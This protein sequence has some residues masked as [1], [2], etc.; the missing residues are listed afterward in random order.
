MTNKPPMPKLIIDQLAQQKGWGPNDLQIEVA[1]LFP[2]L[3]VGY[4][5]ILAL[6][7]N[8]Q[9]NPNLR[10]L[11]AVAATLGVTVPDLFEQAV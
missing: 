3:R 7:H 1:R 2:E 5:T 6:Y 9:T 8:R 4:Q 10:V 11:G